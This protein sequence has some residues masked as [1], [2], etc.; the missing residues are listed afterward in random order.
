MSDNEEIFEPDAEQLQF[1]KEFLE[2]SLI[3]EQDVQTE[4]YSELEDLKDNH[5]FCS[6]LAYFFGLDRTEDNEDICTMAGILLQQSFSSFNDMSGGEQNLVFE[7]IKEQIFSTQQIDR[8]SASIALKELI[9]A[10]EQTLDDFSA[11]GDYMFE[12]L[13]TGSMQYIHG[14]T[15]VLRALSTVDDLLCQWSRIHEIVQSIVSYVSV[16]KIGPLSR[17]LDDLT[18]VYDAIDRDRRKKQATTLSFASARVCEFLTSLLRNNF[19]NIVSNT[20]AL[21]AICVLYKHIMVFNP[22]VIDEIFDEL[23]QFMSMI[24]TYNIDPDE[25]IAENTVVAAMEFFTHSSPEVQLRFFSHNVFANDEDLLIAL[26][27]SVMFSDSNVE[28]FD[29]SLSTESDQHIEDGDYEVAVF[30]QGTAHMKP[31]AEKQ[32]EE[33]DVTDMLPEVRETTAFPVRTAA[34]NLLHEACSHVSKNMTALLSVFFETGLESDDW[35]ELEAASMILSVCCSSAEIV[36]ELIDN[37]LFD[38]MV[39]VE[40]Q[41]LESDNYRLRISGLITLSQC[42]T[43]IMERDSATDEVFGFDVLEYEE[44]LPEYMKIAVSMI[45][46]IDDPK[47][48]VQR[49][50]MNAVLE[51]LQVCSDDIIYILPYLFEMLANTVGKMQRCATSYLCWMIYDISSYINDTF[52]RSDDPELSQQLLYYLSQPLAI[53]VAFIWHLF[54]ELEVDGNP[55]LQF[56]MLGVSGLFSLGVSPPETFIDKTIECLTAAYHAYKLNI[57]LQEGEVDEDD[58]EQ[59]PDIQTSAIPYFFQPL[60]SYVSRMDDPENLIENL[61][62]K[63]QFVELLEA[64]TTIRDPGVQ[65]GLAIVIGS[66]FNTVQVMDHMI[67]NYAE[68]TVECFVS[69][70]VSIKEL[71]QPACTSNNAWCI[72]VMCSAISELNLE[73]YFEVCNEEFFFAVGPE[74]NRANQLGD[75]TVQYNLIVTITRYLK[76]FPDSASFLSVYYDS[77]LAAFRTLTIHGGA[78]DFWS[79]VDMFTELIDFQKSEIIAEKHCRKFFAIVKVIQSLYEASFAHLQAFSPSESEIVE[80]L[81]QS[82]VDLIESIQENE[83][84]ITNHLSV[85]QLQIIK[86]LGII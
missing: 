20:L 54:D 74:L 61:I 11:I 6:C 13:E 86:E 65:A 53:I 55:F 80:K 41:M 56:V 12:A 1:V 76:T 66:M 67:T 39:A 43:D 27:Y 82:M 35:R 21:T 75:C 46:L 68:L 26:M 60:C 3:Q 30:L 77:Y 69:R 52:R 8:N 72:G 28:V 15:S 84:K 24:I 37:D 40:V 73:E 62:E 9:C 10:I 22:S 49:S 32:A 83:P 14:V 85:L 48:H 42:F 18:K 19:D 5:Y 31:Q 50:A 4:V 7:V 29:K 33:Q 57:A 38:Q 25:D 45:N 2:K 34:L 36:N 79:A 59:I 58:L 44:L 70:I 47:K 78:A 51:L 17:V 81:R 63:D 71:D 64:L 23:V 16:D